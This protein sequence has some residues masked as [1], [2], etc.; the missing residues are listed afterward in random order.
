MKK[1]DKDNMLI[2]RLALPYFFFAENVHHRL[3]VDIEM[4][5]LAT[6]LECVAKEARRF[7]PRYQDKG[8]AV[9]YC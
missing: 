9:T 5:G 2:R 6:T 8:R 7:I 4:R 3:Q 1:I